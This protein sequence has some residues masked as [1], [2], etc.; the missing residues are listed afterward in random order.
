MRTREQIINELPAERRAKI[1]ARTKKLVAEEYALQSL[2]K[3]R[4][5]TQVRMA[6]LLHMRQDSV[7]RLENRTD[8]LLSTLRSYV[9][10]MGGSLRLVVEFPD[11]IAE[12]ASLGEQVDL[13][14]HHTVT[15][16]H[17]VPSDKKSRHRRL[18]I[19][20]SSD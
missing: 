10:A 2:R 17:I 15:P 20:H 1:S 6:E 9:E 5:L 14:D 3:A 4:Q 8:L 11:G 12:L 7:S 19:A 13:G 18:A 16:A